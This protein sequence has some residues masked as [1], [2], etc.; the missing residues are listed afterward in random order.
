MVFEDFPVQQDDNGNPVL[1]S[2]SRFIPLE[3]R[4]IFV[5]RKERGF[6]EAYEAL[7]NGEWEYVSYLPDGSFA[8]PPAT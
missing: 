7:R 6:G 2:N 1:D 3:L 4:T 8:T 5:M